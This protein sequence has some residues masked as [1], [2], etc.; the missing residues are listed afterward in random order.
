MTEVNLLFIRAGLDVNGA[1]ALVRELLGLDAR[2]AF[3]RALGV[4]LNDGSGLKLGIRTLRRRQRT[5]RRGRWPGSDSLRRREQLER[6]RRGLG[7]RREQ[8]FG[9]QTKVDEDLLRDVLLL[10]A[11]GDPHRTSKTRAF[12]HV[13]PQGNPSGPG[14]DPLQ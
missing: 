4:R 9:G 3:Q 1:V 6:H 5:R 10:D 11:G 2:E 12:E 8:R 13:Y 7:P 14:E